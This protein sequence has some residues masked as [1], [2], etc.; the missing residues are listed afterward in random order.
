MSQMDF[1]CVLTMTFLQPRRSPK[2]GFPFADAH[3]DS[4]PQQAQLSSAADL[5]SHHSDL[6]YWSNPL[7]PGLRT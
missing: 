4:F 5:N 1:P 7:L 2:A 3:A 6:G